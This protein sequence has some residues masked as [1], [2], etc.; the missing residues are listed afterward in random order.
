M[1]Q[2]ILDLSEQMAKSLFLSATFKAYQSKPE[3]PM[4]LPNED[5]FYESDTP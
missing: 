3:A 5:A 2:R 1:N 4:A